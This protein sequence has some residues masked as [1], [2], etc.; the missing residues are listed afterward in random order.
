MAA[1]LGA[2]S[3]AL[4]PIPF[5]KW[6]M[7]SPALKHRLEFVKRKGGVDFFND[8]KATNVHSVLRGPWSF[9]MIPLFLSWAE[10][11]KGCDFTPLIEPVRRKAKNLILV[12]EAKVTPQSHHRGFQRDLYYRNFWRGGAVSLSKVPQRRCDFIEPWLFQLRHVW[13]LWGS[14][15]T[16]LSSL[17]K[18]S[19]DVATRSVDRSLLMCACALMGI[20]LVLVYSASFIFAYENYGDGLYF[21]K[22]QLFLFFSPSWRFGSRRGFPI[23]I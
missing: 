22:R 21:F 9:W 20:G 6:L 2:R 23:S 18:N 11:D 1:I 13:E 8:S 5:K 12:G 17:S 14:V 3:Y 19:R 7:N 16:T 10:K 15:G 4:S